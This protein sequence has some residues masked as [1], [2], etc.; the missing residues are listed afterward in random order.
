VKAAASRWTWL[1]GQTA[2]SPRRIIVVESLLLTLVLAVLMWFAAKAFGGPYLPSS[3]INDGFGY[4]MGAKSFYLNHTLRGPVLHLDNVSLIGQF[5]SH[6]FVYSLIN[7]GAA[8]LVG[9]H[10]KLIIAINILLL[11]I[12]ALFVLTRSYAWPWKLA[13]LLIFLTYFLT[14]TMTFAY[15]QEIVH[16]LLAL[17]I[18]HLLFIIL[19]SEEPGRKWRL[20]AGYCML[21]AIAALM[22]PSW[23]FWA[24]GLLGIVRSRRDFVVFGSLTLAYIGL[25]YLFIKLFY[26]PYPYYS[27]HDQTLAALKEL[28]VVEAMQAYF[29]FLSE[30][31]SKLFSG[32]FYIFGLTHIP[33]AYT[34]LMIGLTG[35]LFYQFYRY[36]DRFAF[37]VACI[38]A[39]YALAYTLTF[40]ALSAGRHMGV[41]FILQLTYLMKSRKSALV[42]AL[43][44]VQLALFP[45]VVGITDRVIDVQAR[46]GEYAIKNPEWVSAVRGL[47]AAIAI[48]RPATIYLDNAFHYTEFPVTIHLPLQGAD[49]QALRYS[50]DLAATL[51]MA[52]RKFDGGFLDF[53]LSA[54]PLARSDLTLKYR[55]DDLY[56]YQLEGRP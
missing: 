14:P 47:G 21:I 44:V 39:P 36:R 46:A 34:F 18:G 43:A 1:F 20:L 7:G 54:K 51:P 22:R 11:A 53:V 30:N 25:G 41:I 49:G 26:A 56:L 37:A 38:A 17:V 35:Y 52:A 15:M 10:D 8:I 48:D 29:G 32:N 6:A 12:C 24:A 9:W 13:F 27:P 3:A 16:L 19:K 50:Q 40:D 23:A 31:L 28:R 5:D 4:F 2:V 45:T 33:N 42:T 55:A